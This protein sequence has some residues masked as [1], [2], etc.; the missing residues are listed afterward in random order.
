MDLKH[1]VVGWFEIPVID[2]DRAV[3]FYEQV[4][5]FSLVRHQ[6]GPLEMAWFPWVEGAMG[7][8]GSLVR[9]EFHRPSG[10]GVRIYFTAHS[11]DVAVEAGRAEAA[12]GALV[13]PKT[14]IS[15]DI[16]YMAVVRDT[17][18]NRIALHAKSK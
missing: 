3:K 16:G 11:G 15:E 10:E 1:N 6:L 5:G 7:S 18:G 9:S 8:S 17:E 4:F 14:L 13:M 2:M 12:G